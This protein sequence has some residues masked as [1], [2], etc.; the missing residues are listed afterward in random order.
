MTERPKILCVDDEPNVLEGLKLHLRRHYTVHTAT[1]GPLALECLEREGPFAVVLSD[2]RMPGM[3]GATLLGQIRRRSPDT[4][5]M[6]LTGHADLDSAIAAVNEGQLF[7][8]LLKPCPPP[9]LLQA[10]EAGIAQYRL[11]TAERVLLEQTL[12][13]VIQTLTNILA[14]THPVAFGRANRLKRHAV[15]LARQI[16]IHQDLWPLEVAAMLSQIGCIILPDETLEKLYQGGVPGEKERAMLERVPTVTEQLLGNI[17]RL[18]AVL[19]IL[20]N[21]D[22][23][24]RF[25]PAKLDAVHVG[26]PILKLVGDFD[27]LINQGNSAELALDTL[28]SRSGRYDPTLLDAFAAIRSP[29]GQRRAIKEVAIL[30][31]QIGMIFAEDVR[32]KTGVL[33]VTRG[34]EVTPGLLERLHNLQGVE[35]LPPVKVVMATA[36]ADAADG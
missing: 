28:R 17:P 23:L 29:T 30:A 34:H 8:F 12:R 9:T 13:G 35:T 32:A 14:L 20:G 36:A 21:R 19:S 2:M 33:L 16:G 24:Y 25:D 26:G 15:D 10:F 27:T 4:T 31:L 11:L 3:D 18:E 22:K 1:G 7:R 6:L 5:R